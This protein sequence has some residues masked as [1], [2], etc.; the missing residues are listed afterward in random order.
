MISHIVTP[1]IS[2]I[3]II[4]SGLIKYECLGIA[5]GLIRVGAGGLVRS[6]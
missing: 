1:Q 5:N 4:Y 3:I 6:Q 2:Y